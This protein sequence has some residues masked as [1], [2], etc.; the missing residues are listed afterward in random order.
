MKTLQAISHVGFSDVSC[1]FRGLRTKAQA[2]P[3]PGRG[4]GDFWEKRN[5]R[6]ASDEEPTAT[7]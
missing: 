2:R 3:S 6:A 7:P 4:T 5:H 1:C